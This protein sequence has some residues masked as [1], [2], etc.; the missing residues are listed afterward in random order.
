M[1]LGPLQSVCQARFFRYLHLR[2]LA[3]TSASRVWC[4]IGDGEMDEPETIYAIARAGYERLNNLVMIVNC[5]YQRLDGPVRGNSKVIQEFEGI[6]RGAG[7]DCIKLIWGDAWNDLV[8]NDHDG[9]LIEVLERTP[10]GDCQRYAAK[11]DGGLIRREIFEAN[12]LADRVAHFSDDELLSAF[13]LPGGHDHKKIYAAMSQ[14]AKNAE[15]GGRPTVILAKTLKGFSLATFQ[16]RNTVHQ[17][18][19]LKVEEMLSFRDVLEIPLTDEQI[20]NPEGGEFFR[21][22]GPESPEVQYIMNNREKLGGCLPMRS[23]AKVSGLIDLPSSELYNLFDQ[24]N[25]KCFVFNAMAVPLDVLCK[26][27]FTREDGGGTGRLDRAHF[28][29][30]LQRVFGHVQPVVPQPDATWFDKVYE[31]YAAKCGGNGVSLRAMEDAAKQFVSHHQ[32]KRESAKQMESPTNGQL[33][34]SPKEVINAGKSTERSLEA[35]VA[36]NRG[37]KQVIEEI[38][39]PPALPQVPFSPTRA[40]LSNAVPSRPGYGKAVELASA[41]M[42][43]MKHNSTV[44]EDYIMDAQKLGEGSFGQVCVVTQRLTGQKRACK[45]V[46]IQTEM[47]RRL[48]ETEIQLFKKLDHGNIMRLSECYVDGTSL[49]L[50]SELCE[51]GTLL[52]GFARHGS[53]S[54]AASALRQ[55]LSCSVAVAVTFFCSPKI[56]TLLRMS[57]DSGLLRWV[58]LLNLC[59]AVSSRTH[60]FSRP[61]VEQPLRKDQV[62]ELLGEWRTPDPAQGARRLS[63]AFGVSEQFRRDWRLDVHDQVEQVKIAPGGKGEAVISWLTKNRVVHYK[64]ARSLWSRMA[65]GEVNVYTTQICLPNSQVMTDPLLGPPNIPLNYDELTDLLNTSAFLPKDPR[66]QR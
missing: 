54:K 21:K 36:A 5:N 28:Q 45:R 17:Q 43:P 15:S 24:G 8:D 51:G 37:Q 41:V 31:S 39:P 2:G 53:E 10:D 12:G 23:P 44:M 47:D 13:M 35:K 19:S 49:F 42:C 66:F 38:A 1:G 65:Q 16:G 3:D 29:S 25:P 20:K 52:Q 64:S 27:C 30:A 48:V 14:A 18:K 4:F 32:K 62:I 56:A 7:F 33:P 58:W 9:K 6:F 61:P 26:E 55:I 22:P 50:I 34:S 57:H 63:H 60:V 59:Q 11:Q 40:A 46:Q